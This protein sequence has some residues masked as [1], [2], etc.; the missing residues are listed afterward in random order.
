MDR[1]HQCGFAKVLEY[2]SADQPAV[3]ALPMSAAP[4]APLRPLSVRAAPRTTPRRSYATT[5]H[6]RPLWMASQ[7]R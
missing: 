2:S 7:A 6:E 5:T 4:P 3:R 1:L